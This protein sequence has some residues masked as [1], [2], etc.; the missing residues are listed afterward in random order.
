MLK[1]IL[2]C[3]DS[4]VQ[5][6][7]HGVQV[8]LQDACSGSLNDKCAPKQL[9]IYTPFSNVSVSTRMHQQHYKN[10]EVDD[11]EASGYFKQPKP[12]GQYEM[13]IDIPMLRRSIYR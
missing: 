11:C 10:I 6:L 8:Y 4:L 3:A 13:C 1:T 7:Q 12:T 5:V 2:F 9:E